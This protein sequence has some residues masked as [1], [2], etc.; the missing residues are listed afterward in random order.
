MD[1]LVECKRCGGNAC[2]EQHFPDGT[3]TWLD[4]GCGFTTSTL[5]TVNS[6]TVNTALEASPELYKDLAYIDEDKRVWLPATITVPEVGM[7]FIDGKS[8]DNWK[9]KATKAIYKDEQW[10][11]DMKSAKEYNQNDFMEAMD[12]LGLFN[13]V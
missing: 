9:W 3:I 6:S 7:V 1:K 13:G 12:F 8:L 5:M 10:K 2:Y 11:M 4:L